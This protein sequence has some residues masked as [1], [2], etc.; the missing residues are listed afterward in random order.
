MPT[1][2]FVV[3]TVPDIIKSIDVAR[4]LA[5]NGI[6]VTI[7]DTLQNRCDDV[8]PHVG[9]QIIRSSVIRSQCRDDLDWVACCASE[10][11]DLCGDLLVV[12]GDTY[13]ALAGAHGAVRAGTPL[14]HIEAGLR[15]FDP[16]SPFPEEMNRVFIDTQSDLLFCATPTDRDDLRATVSLEAKQSF[17]VGNTVCDPI[18]HHRDQLRLAAAGPDGVLVSLHRRENYRHRTPILQALS[19]LIARFP[20][21]R[22]RLLKRGLLAH[23]EAAEFGANACMVGMTEH[24]QFLAMLAE[25]QIAICDSGG[26]LEEAVTLGVPVICL[27]RTLER[28]RLVDGVDCIDPA[29]IGGPQLPALVG[30]LLSGAATERGTLRETFG[31]GR[32]AERVAALLLDH[33]DRR[34]RERRGARQENKQESL[35]APFGPA[36]AREA[37]A[38]VAM[39]RPQERSRRTAAAAGTGVDACE[40]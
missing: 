23:S 18:F 31:D 15:S 30:R 26:I 28:G 12:Q 14:A 27:R 3:G 39:P 32:S 19:R 16:L 10:I 33:L 25:S 2:T 40:P 11:A 22:F 37:G 36:Q 7:Y 21:T 9:V 17:V 38:P 20:D 24:L 1:V 35:R 13:S 34:A 8:A 4:Q 6:D 29:D 5:D